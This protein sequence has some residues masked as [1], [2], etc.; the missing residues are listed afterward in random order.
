MVTNVDITNIDKIYIKIVSG[1]SS[2]FDFLVFKQN[3]EPLE[4]SNDMLMAIEETK[5]N[6]DESRNTAV[7]QRASKF[8][9][10]E[11]YSNNVKKYM[12]YNEELNENIYK[13][14]SNTNIFGTRLLHTLNVSII[15]KK[16]S[17]N[18]NSF[19]SIDELIEFKNKMRKPPTGNVPIEITK[20]E[21]RI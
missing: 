10:I 18:Y 9:F 15:G 7:Y 8:I 20:Y 3:E 1:K 4:G 17:Y 21:D 6:D 11:N 13:K 12:L 19:K 2:F 5:T 14:T 16:S